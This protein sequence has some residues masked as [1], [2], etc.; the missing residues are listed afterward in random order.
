[1][2]NKDWQLPCFVSLRLSG[3]KNYI[4]GSTM[5]TLTTFFVILSGVEGWLNTLIKRYSLQYLYFI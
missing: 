5:L 2:L 3:I 4:H 1:M